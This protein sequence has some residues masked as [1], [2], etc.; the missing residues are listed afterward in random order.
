MLEK[1]KEMTVIDL[2]LQK[3]MQNNHIL[4]L[5]KAEQMEE[6]FKVYLGGKVTGHRDKAFPYKFLKSINGLII[7]LIKIFNIKLI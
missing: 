5:S 2:R 3:I 7:R 1:G 6:L 4:M